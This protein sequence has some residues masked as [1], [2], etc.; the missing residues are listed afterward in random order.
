M[1]CLFEG[2]RGSISRQG[3]HDPGCK[4]G[5]YRLCDTVSNSAQQIFHPALPFR[6]TRLAGKIQ[7]RL[8]LLHPSVE[9]DMCGGRIIGGDRI[10]IQ[11][12]EIGLVMS[13]E[14]ADSWISIPFNS[15]EQE[16]VGVSY[17]HIFQ[18]FAGRKL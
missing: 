18:E 9:V 12:I 2:A 1:T 10:A 15:E 16:K 13:A 8:G 4:F 3:T 6:S 7:S 17:L 5:I 11:S 14:T